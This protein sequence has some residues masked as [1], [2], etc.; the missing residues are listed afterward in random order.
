MLFGQA[1]PA[2]VVVAASLPIRRPQATYF[3]ANRVMMMAGPMAITAIEESLHDPREEADMHGNVRP[4]DAGIG[5]ADVEIVADEIERQDPGN[6]RHG[7][8]QIAGAKPGARKR[9]SLEPLATVA[10]L[11]TTVARVASSAV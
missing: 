5:V 10:P 2:K 1:R 8:E 9:E 4:Q 3:W 7:A 6:R 11:E